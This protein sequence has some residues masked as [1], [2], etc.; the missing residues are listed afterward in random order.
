MAPTVVAPRLVR[1]PA[2]VV[3]PVP[4]EVSAKAFVRL[5][6]PILEEAMVVVA[7]VE[8]AVTAKFVVVAA[9]MVAFVPMRFAKFAVPVNVGDAE[10]TNE[11]VPVIPVTSVMRVSSLVRVSIEVLEILLL[12][13][14]QSAEVRRPRAEA[15]ADGILSV[16]V[17]P[18]ETGEADQLMSEPVLPVAKAMVEFVKPAL[19]R[20]PVIVGVYVRVFPLPTMVRPVVRPLKE[21]VLVAW[22]MVGPVWS[23]VAGPKEVMAPPVAMKPRLEVATQRVEVPVVWSTWPRVPAVPVMSRSAAVS[24]VVE[25]VEVAVTAKLVVV[26]FVVVALVAIKFA[27]V[28]R[29]VS[30]EFTTPLPRV[31][32]VRTFVPAIW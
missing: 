4:P 6:V 8:V 25:R 17:P 23:W 19:L 7:K 2:A 1:A 28:P 12:N 15:E 18:K 14:D 5:S 27:M 31:L 24:E 29:L 13:S 30:D 9:V 20:V 3:A 11:P 10:R 26:A 22:V 16:A 21:P 32:A